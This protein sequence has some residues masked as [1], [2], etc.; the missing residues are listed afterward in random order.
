MHRKPWAARRLVAPMQAF[1]VLLLVLAAPSAPGPHP[2]SRSTSLVRIDERGAS[3]E[4]RCQARTLSEA[5]PLDANRDGELDDVELSAGRDQVE[6]YLLEHYQLFPGL[7]QGRDGK[8]DPSHALRGRQTGLRVIPASE[9]ALEEPWVAAQ[10][11]FE[12]NA[13]L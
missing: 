11:E 13:E 4:F 7:D 3:L 5:L 6:A 10:F 1:L 2:D 8:F 9:S 12:S